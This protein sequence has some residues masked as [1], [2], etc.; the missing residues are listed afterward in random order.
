LHHDIAKSFLESSRIIF[1]WSSWTELLKA[2]TLQI[3][4]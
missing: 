2:Q 3:W 1:F 4:C